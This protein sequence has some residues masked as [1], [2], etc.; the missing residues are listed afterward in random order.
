MRIGWSGRIGVGLIAFAAIADAATWLV[1]AVDPYPFGFYQISDFCLPIAFLFG[2]ALLLPGFSEALQRRRAANLARFPL[3]AVGPAP[4]HL[5]LDPVHAESRKDG[6]P[7]DSVEPEAIT[8]PKLAFVPSPSHR[9]LFLWLGLTCLFVA[10]CVHVSVQSWKESLFFRPL[11][12]PISIDHGRLRSAE[13]R[14]DF[15]AVFTLKLGL[16]ILA[17]RGAQFTLIPHRRSHGS[18]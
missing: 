13:F 5:R 15:R 9:K 16:P 2:L 10:A 1:R 17:S 14:T 11:D 8:P 4:A 3:T 18:S 12:V 6:G 7:S